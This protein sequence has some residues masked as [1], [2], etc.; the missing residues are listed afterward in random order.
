MLN[1]SKGNMYSF[2]THTWNTV[3]GVCPHNC[4][5]CYMKQF[6]QKEVRFD[7]KE[8]KTDLGNGNFIFVGSSCDLFADAIPKEWILE[9]LDHCRGYENKY[10]F[11]SKNP[12]RMRNFEDYIPKNSIL[13]TT[14]ETDRFYTEYMGNAPLPLE[15]ARALSSL[16]MNFK[17]MVT[18]EPIIK[19]CP[20]CLWNLICICSPE[21]VNIG[22]DSKGS[23]LPEPDADEISE[24]IRN[25]RHEGIT[26]KIKDNLKRLKYW[27]LK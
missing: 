16:S 17:T 4:A 23:G 27:Q 26:V 3:K 18:I 8:L 11:Q 10:L 2:V 25:L 14:I 21:W 12:Q 9:T 6:P 19:F 1:P 7:K 24:L 20:L 15:R 13:G 5:Y 22:A